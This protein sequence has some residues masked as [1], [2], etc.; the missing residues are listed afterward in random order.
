M[1][2]FYVQRKMAGAFLD[3]FKMEVEI[4]KMSTW[5]LDIWNFD[6]TQH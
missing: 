2:D 4:A 5:W 1:G 3:N 6:T